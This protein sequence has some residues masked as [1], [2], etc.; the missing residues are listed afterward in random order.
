MQFHMMLHFNKYQPDIKVTKSN[1]LL[2]ADRL[3]FFIK[4]DFEGKPVK[5]YVIYDYETKIQLSFAYEKEEIEP[6]LY[7]MFE[8]EGVIDDLDSFFKG[9]LNE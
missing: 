3:F 5:G 4:K 7:R 2:V 1:S 6:M 8:R 9:L